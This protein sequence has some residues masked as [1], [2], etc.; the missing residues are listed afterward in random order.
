FVRRNGIVDPLFIPG[1]HSVE[2]I[3]EQQG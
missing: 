2:V 1:G 3:S